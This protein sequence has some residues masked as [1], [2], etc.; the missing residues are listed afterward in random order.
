M[1]KVNRWIRMGI[2]VMAEVL[3]FLVVLSFGLDVYYGWFGEK[4]GIETEWTGREA[5][6]YRYMEEM[7]P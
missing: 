3:L 7:R 5:G 6:D 4:A 1:E 2:I